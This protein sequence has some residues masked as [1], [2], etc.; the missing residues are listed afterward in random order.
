M[1]KSIKTKPNEIHQDAYDL[2]HALGQVN[3]LSKGKSVSKSEQGSKSHLTPDT[4]TNIERVEININNKLDSSSS[5]DS[6]IKPILS[7]ADVDLKISKSELKYTK[8]QTDLKDE[9]TKKLDSF[10]DKIEKYKKEK[11][12]KEPFWTVIGIFAPVLLSVLGYIIV[13]IFDVKNEI[14][15][16][17]YQLEEVDNNNFPIK[18]NHLPEDSLDVCSEQIDC[19][20]LNVPPISL[21]NVPG[22]SE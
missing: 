12:S 9:I 19:S 13:Q 21:S 16:I 20:T 6:G 15:L 14:S 17:K 18:E 11:I 22:I 10:A 8:S 7:E 1:A 3:R 4:I 2:R 5:T